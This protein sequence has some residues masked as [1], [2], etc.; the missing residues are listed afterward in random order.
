MSKKKKHVWLSG[1]LYIEGRLK[2]G[3]RLQQKHNKDE[4]RS[5]AKQNNFTR[6][7]KQSRSW[8]AEHGKSEKMKKSAS[9]PPSSPWSQ[10]RKTPFGR[11]E[12]TTYSP[13]YEE[14]AEMVYKILEKSD[15]SKK[16]KHVWLSG[17]LYIEGRLKEGPRLQRKHNKDEKRSKAKQNNF[18][19]CGKQ[20]RSW[21]AEHG[22]NEKMKKSASA[23]PSSPW[24]QGRKTP[25][26]RKERTTYSPTYEE[27]AEIV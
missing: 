18:T 1:H 13:T 8:S 4:K 11:K 6:C 5:K 26:G 10:G 19:R 25:F 24:S 12:R 22:K 27:K 21:S 9:A 16:K 17:H 20:S 2:E 7:G 3:P 15:M 14:K 23:P